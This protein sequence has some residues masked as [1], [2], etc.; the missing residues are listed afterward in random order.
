MSA[1]EVTVAGI[2][3]Y[4]GPGSLGANHKSGNQ[5]AAAGFSTTGQCL[6][7][8]LQEADPRSALTYK[9]IQLSI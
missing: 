1:A 9:G 3:P 5:S 2:V 7:V 6:R 8:Y 4:L